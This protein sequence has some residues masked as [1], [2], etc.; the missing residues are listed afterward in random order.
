MP[1]Y[2]ARVRNGV[3]RPRSRASE[4]ICTTSSRVGAMTS[5]RGAPVPGGGAGAGV[6]S[7]LVKAA[8][9][10]AAVFPVPVCAWPATSFP[11]SAT[12][13]AAS[14]IGVAVTKPAARIPSW[15]GA[16]RSSCAN[17]MTRSGRRGGAPAEEP[18]GDDPR[19][20]EETERRR[21]EELVEGVGGRRE[22]GRDD[23][24]DEDRVLPV[25]GKELRRHDPEPGG[26]GH[27][28]R[29]LEDEAEGERELDD[30]VDVAGQGELDQH[31][32]GLVAGQELDGERDD[33]AQREAGA[34]GEE[35]GRDQDEGQRELPLRGRR[36]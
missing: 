24:V 22:D 4:S 26:Q 7:I 21:H 12:G 17:S 8:M 25:L 1:P 34:E 13:R 11:R 16:G 19:L 5:M 15:T 30:E 33:H 23:E 18:R 35:G 2:T 32:T 31:V 27:G 3:N 36:P 28:E 10:N 6:R 14:W 20:V 9:R 29:Q